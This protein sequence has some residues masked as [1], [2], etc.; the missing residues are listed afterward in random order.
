MKRRT[1]IKDMAVGGLALNLPHGLLAQGD[2]GPKLAQVTGDDPARR[3]HHRA[4]RPTS[5]WLSSTNPLF[6]RIARFSNMTRM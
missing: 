6:S 3:T 5:R 4:A 2:A 1:F